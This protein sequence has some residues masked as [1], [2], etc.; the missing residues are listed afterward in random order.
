MIRH[1]ADVG[2][3]GEGQAQANESAEKDPTR[4]DRQRQDDAGQHQQTR[5]Q[6]NLA[7]QRPTRLYAGHD[8][9]AGFDPAFVPPSRTAIC[10]WQGSSRPGGHVCTLTRL[11]DEDD[12]KIEQ[13]RSLKA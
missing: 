11:A 1:R 13:P 3:S 12:G 9:E 4:I 8:G 7:L 5:A 2:E 6:T 10:R